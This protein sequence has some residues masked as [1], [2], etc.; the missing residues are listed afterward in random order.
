MQK[1]SSLVERQHLLF[2]LGGWGGY[3]GTTCGA[4]MIFG[5]GVPARVD[6]SDHLSFFIILSPTLSPFDRGGSTTNLRMTYLQQSE[7]LQHHV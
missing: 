7:N 5:E 1:Y 3:W 6:T 4:N 2:G